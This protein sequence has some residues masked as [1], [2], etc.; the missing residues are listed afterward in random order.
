MKKIKY[1]LVGLF[2][3]LV[4][5]K[6]VYASELKQTF[7]TEG[8]RVQAEHQL[9]VPSY[10][11]DGNVDGH[12]ICYLS[13]TENCSKY[14]LSNELV[15]TTDDI[16]D[17][18]INVETI[19]SENDLNLTVNGRKDIAIIK[20]KDESD[21]I[22]WISQYGGNKNEEIIAI[23]KSYDNKEKHDGYL[24]IVITNS[25]NISNITPGYV[26]VKHD[27]EGI[28][29]WNK[30]INNISNIIIEEE[31]SI[32]L[33]N[34]STI[35]FFQEG[36][37]QEV[38]INLHGNKIIQSK[39]KNNENDGYIV[40]GTTYEDM[41][42]PNDI[43]NY[44]GSILSSNY[45]DTKNV[46][47]K[48]DND[49]NIIWSKE[50][51][52]YKNTVLYD[53][54]LSK[55]PSGEVDGYLA[56]GMASE[57]IV[58]NRVTDDFLDNSYNDKTIGL[59]IKYDLDG[60]I[61]FEEEFDTKPTALTS[62]SENYDLNGI[63]N[64]YIIVG[65]LYDESMQPQNFIKKVT[66]KKLINSN[67][68][69]KVDKSVGLPF[70]TYT[71]IILKYTYQNYE[72]EK[73]VETGGNVAIYENAYPGTIVPINVKVEEGYI[74][75]KLTIQDT[76][77]AEVKVDNNSFIM[78]EGKVIVTAKFKKLTNPQTSALGY[79]LVFIVILVGVATFTVRNQK[80]EEQEI[81]KL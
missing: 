7:N 81:E 43:L 64:G 9:I 78:P 13:S 57:Y 28:K 77:G 27:L 73:K 21:D 41:Y 50:Y 44:P 15:W 49:G 52:K 54:I 4:V 72:I 33:D 6:T 47:V 45:F 70:P 22:E 55:T 30:N 32:G 39:N 58:E 35:T 20:Y 76:D 17:Y 5:P 12:L 37:E 74:L 60:N 34:S 16:Y 46:I 67:D 1:L 61:V 26:L 18:N 80:L 24:S 69:N 68:Q 38:L 59:F 2:L 48:T 42:M 23:I 19:F 10:N 63:F 71:Q 40:V 56:V 36:N 51:T 29:L 53:V 31:K 66:P 79:T 8:S 3:L 11:N 62:I 25:T 14:D 65:H 75:E